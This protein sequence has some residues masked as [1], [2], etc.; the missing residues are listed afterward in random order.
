MDNS[1]SVK[2]ST[3]KGY[4]R[5][6]NSVIRDKRLKLETRMLLSIILQL[7]KSWKF[8]IKGLA[9]SVG[10]TENKV[11]TMLSELSEYG[12]LRRKKLMPSAKTGGKI[13]Y[14]YEFFEEPIVNN[15]APEQIDN[16]K[17]T[18]KKGTKFNT[19]STPENSVAE[20]QDTEKSNTYIKSNYSKTNN[21]YRSISQSKSKKK[22]YI[23]NDS[24]LMSEEDPIV[25]E[26]KEQINY[27]SIIDGKN[28]RLIDETIKAMFYVRTTSKKS[29]NI[30]KHSVD[31]SKVQ[32]K[33][34]DISEKDVLNVIKSVET[35]ND[36]Y[37]LQKYL[38]SSLYNIMNTNTHRTCNPCS[39]DD[40]NKY[41]CLANR[42]PDYI[43]DSNYTTDLQDNTLSKFP[44]HTELITG[45]HAEYTN[46]DL[47]REYSNLM[48]ELKTFLS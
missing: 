10:S 46:Y 48:S 20:L 8:T 7:P 34:K 47:Q 3:D 45:H 30:N 43:T 1:F 32:T 40:I 31:I 14:S 4:T 18:S 39:D 13:S 12:Y 19:F 33:F 16:K 26:L 24:T 11:R 22:F 28:K 6:S 25:S 2:R 9:V 21:Y 29:I 36:I 44:S 38:I 23:N 41:K 42:F 17:S 37:C 5:I 35:K 15:E 27:G